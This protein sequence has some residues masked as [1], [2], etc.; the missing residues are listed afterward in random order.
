VKRRDESELRISDEHRRCG[1]FTLHEIEALPIP[2]RL[3]SFDTRVVRTTR[4]AKSF[5]WHRR[6]A[7]CLPVQRDWFRFQELVC[8]E[9]AGTAPVSTTMENLWECISKHAGCKKGG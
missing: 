3:P 4:L 8:K 2:G 6:F 7:R 5:A 9:P 1:F